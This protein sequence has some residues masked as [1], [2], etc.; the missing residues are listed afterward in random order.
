[1]PHSIRFSELSNRKIRTRLIVAIPIIIVLLVS[2]SGLIFLNVSERYFRS[3]GMAQD[4][5]ALLG[6]LKVYLFISVGASFFIGLVMAFAITLPIN[7]LTLGTRDVAKGD[8]SKT[9]RINSEDEIGT[10]GKS[11]NEMLT[12]LNEHILESMTGGVIRF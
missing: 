11:F 7:R 12:S 5:N 2:T 9:V 4:I 8:L 10:L 1:M 3:G 6:N